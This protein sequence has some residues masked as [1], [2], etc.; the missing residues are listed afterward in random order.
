V[1]ALTRR[2]IIRAALA[3]VLGVSVWILSDAILEQA[4]TE[5]N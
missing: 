4:R 1:G 2:L 3:V 5:Q